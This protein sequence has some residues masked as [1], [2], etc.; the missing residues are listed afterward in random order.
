MDTI[1]VLDAFPKPNRKTAIRQVS[2]E[3]GGQVAT[4]LVTT[5]RLGLR[6][7][8]IGTVGSDDVGVGQIV[9]LQA[10]G[11]DTEPVRMIDGALSPMSIILLEEGI[12]ERTVLWHRDAR[13]Q[14]PVAELR[15]DWICSGRILHLDGCDSRAALQAAGWAREAGIPVMI[16]ID[17]IYDASTHELLGLVDYLIA[18]EEF[19]AA[20]S[21]TADAR[22]GARILAAR[23]QCPVVGITC[24]V[25][26]AFFV[27]KE[28]SF[29]SPAFR[30]TAVDTTGAGDV[31]H[32]AFIYG[33]LQ[34][35]TIQ[36]TA[37]F[38]HAAAAMKC[39]RMGA[40]RGIPRLS[41]VQA[42]LRE[43]AE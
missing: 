8:Y 23:Y 25:K 21:G 42:F 9:S 32:G 36:D 7:R 13:L 15:R 39:T 3:A 18:A 41:E 4:A 11:I 29:E 5:A 34:H 28:M 22:D 38:A 27:N 19:A 14:Y 10:E 37:R 1:C 35:W 24:G 16:D 31:F 40:R 26:G 33:L 20:V 17:V 43:A 30:I 12:G 6:S 2:R